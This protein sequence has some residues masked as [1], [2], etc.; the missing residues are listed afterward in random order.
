MSG[1]IRAPSTGIGL[2]KPLARL[3][4]VDVESAR[5]AIFCFMWS[6]H[7]HGRPVHG[8]P[9]LPRCDAYCWRPAG[10]GSRARGPVPRSAV[11]APL[12]NVRS[13]HVAHHAPQPRHR[14]VHTPPWCSCQ[15]MLTL[16]PWWWFVVVV[17]VLPRY[18][19]SIFQS[20][21]SKSLLKEFPFP[22]TMTMGQVSVHGAANALTQACLFLFSVKCGVVCLG[23][24]VDGSSR[25]VVCVTRVGSAASLPRHTTWT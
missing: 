13:R 14:A 11:L 19:T 2:S 6:V 1:R 21:W 22:M 4:G 16:W 9:V 7:L 8:S 3:F 20:I 18:I 10:T 25:M 17:C 24:R 12:P 15:C 23:S 5:L